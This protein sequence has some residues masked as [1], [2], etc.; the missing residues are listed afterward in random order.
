MFGALQLTAGAQFMQVGRWMGHAGY[1]VTMA[2]SAN[3]VAEE[4]AVNTLPEPMPELVTN[5]VPLH[6]HRSAP[7]AGGTFTAFL[8]F[9]WPVSVWDTLLQA[10]HRLRG[11]PR[12]AKTR[13][14]VAQYL[15]VAGGLKPVVLGADGHQVAAMFVRGTV[16]YDVEEATFIAV[17]EEG[18]AIGELSVA[19]M[20]DYDENTDA[21]VIRTHTS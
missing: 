7:L 9:V 6:P 19:E 4:D 17:A 16:T 10:K 18:Q 20:V 15:K 8:G 11:N 21:F 13:A 12:M 3:W 2:V 5:V 1:R 14:E